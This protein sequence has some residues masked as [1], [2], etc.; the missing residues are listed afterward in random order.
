VTFNKLSVR[1]LYPLAL[2]EGEG[3]GT[4]YEYRAKRLV[5]AR[6]LGLAPSLKRILIAGLPEKYGASLDFALMAAEFQAHLTVAD[7]RPAALDKFSDSLATLQAQG[8]ASDLVWEPLLVPDLASL[9]AT[10]GEYDLALSSEVLQRLDEP[11]RGPYVSGLQ[12]LASRVALFCPNAEN[13]AHTDLSGLA[14]LTKEEAC[15]LVGDLPEDGRADGPADGGVQTGLVDMPPFP[16]GITRSDEQRE[17][18]SSG[19]AEALAMSGLDAY[20]RLEQYVPGRI[21]RQKCHI[22]YVLLQAPVE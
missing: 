11:A 13:P 20:A 14:G 5:L 21:R 4:A 7:D 18:A 10:A 8:I 15:G 12:R 2:A 19:R 3:V 22:V 1:K 16:P 17:Q 9:P 6:W